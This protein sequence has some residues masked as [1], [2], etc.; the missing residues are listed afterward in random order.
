MS[1]Q[2]AVAAAL[3]NKG[4]DVPNCQSHSEANQS[5]V[6]FLPWFLLCQKGIDAVVVDLIRL[7][8]GST[9]HH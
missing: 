2:R 5:L 6:R 7:L 8:I 4:Y 9:E 3:V 1:E